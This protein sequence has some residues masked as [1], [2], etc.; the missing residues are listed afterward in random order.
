MVGYLLIVC[1][2]N[3]YNINDTSLRKVSRL[4]HFNT[5]FL[6]GLKPI[7]LGVFFK[8]LKYYQ[9]RNRQ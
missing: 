1:L 4:P 2:Q 3:T 8:M 7:F 9:S 6:N 5:F